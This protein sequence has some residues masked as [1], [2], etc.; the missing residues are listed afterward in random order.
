MSHQEVN[1]RPTAN[2]AARELRAQ[3]LTRLR[4]FFTEREVLEVETPLLSAAATVDPNI[5]SFQTQ[6][7]GP[8]GERSLYLAT[9]PEFAMKRLLADGS[10]P[11]YQVCKAFRQGEAGA[12]HNPEFTLLEWYRPGFDH[13][14]LMS[15]VEA[16]VR[17][18]A[19]DR[20][21]LGET[22]TLTYGEAFQRELQLDPHATAL[23]Q[24]RQCAATAL[25]EA[26]PHLGEDRDAW[27][28]LL[29]SHCVQPHLGHERLTFVRDYPASQAALARIRPGSPPLAE[30]FELFYAGVELANGFHEL[31][32]ADEQKDRFEKEQHLRQKRS[33]NDVPMDKHLLA[34]LDN[35]MP[36]CAGVAMGLDRILLLLQGG[37]KLSETLNFPIDRA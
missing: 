2:Q 35:G 3:T 17:C 22:E 9:S 37:T 31:T 8:G 33:F 13:H 7:D 26:L 4:Q 16:L 5:Q 15:E 25:G 1:W 11:I 29:M 28:D 18:L 24:L 10:G 30:R 12:W 27:L 23:P 6:Y 36:D 19:E 14:R 32:H 20:L 34:A 21:A